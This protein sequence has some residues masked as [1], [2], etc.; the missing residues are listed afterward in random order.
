MRV[1]NDRIV[2]ITEVELFKL[3]LQYSLDDIIDFH[4]YKQ[5]MKKS[6]CVIIE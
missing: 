3:Y 5:R 4:E 6:G 2:E 1:E